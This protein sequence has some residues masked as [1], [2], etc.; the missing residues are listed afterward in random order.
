MNPRDLIRL[1]K[2][3]IDASIA[4]QELAIVVRTFVIRHTDG[5]DTKEV[6]E[7]TKALEDVWEAPDWCQEWLNREN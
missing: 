1:T 3:A 6:F 5:A 7:H 4:A 2:A